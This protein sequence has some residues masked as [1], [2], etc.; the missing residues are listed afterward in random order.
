VP[1]GEAVVVGDVEAVLVDVVAR[2][3][4]P[5]LEGPGWAPAPSLHPDSSTAAAALT[6]TMVALA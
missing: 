5:P 2:L 6:V 1:D 4:G 3:E